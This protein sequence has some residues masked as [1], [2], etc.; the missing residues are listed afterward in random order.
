V[1][2]PKCVP[3]STQVI[4]PDLKLVYILGRTETVPQK[5]LNAV[6]RML[7]EHMYNFLRRNSRTVAGTFNV[8]KHRLLEVGVV[9]EI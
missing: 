1:H 3:A 8:P 4:D 5:G 2:C 6:V 9:V 7:L